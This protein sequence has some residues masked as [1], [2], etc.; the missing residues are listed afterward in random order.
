[1]FQNFDILAMCGPG[2]TRRGCKEIRYKTIL[3]K[4]PTAYMKMILEAASWAFQ[5]WPAN[6]NVSTQHVSKASRA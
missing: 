2:K 5:K 6:Q 3:P 1:M 4:R